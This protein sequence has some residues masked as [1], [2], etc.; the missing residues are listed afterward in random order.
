MK[1]N[2]IKLSHLGSVRL[3]RLGVV[4]VFLAIVVKRKS[5]TNKNLP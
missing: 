4:I 3:A 2:L 1:K 5:L